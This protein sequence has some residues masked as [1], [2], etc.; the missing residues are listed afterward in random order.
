MGGGSETIKGAQISGLSDKYGA[1]KKK[2]LLENGKNIPSGM[3]MVIKSRGQSIVDM[4]S[5]YNKKYLEAMGYAPGDD[6]LIDKISEGKI[7]EYTKNN[8]DSA[9]TYVSNPEINTLGTLDQVI[10]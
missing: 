6:V 5:L 3:N 2:I 1:L 8:I 9:A 10:L 4:K 7:L